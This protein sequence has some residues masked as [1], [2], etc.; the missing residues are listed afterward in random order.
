VLTAAMQEDPSNARIPYTLG[1]VQ[2]RLG[3][4]EAA[5]RALERFVQ[6]ASC[7]FPTQVNEV[8][9]RLAGMSQ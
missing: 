3:D 5:R 6:I 2:L 4:R 8:K 7:R 1:Q 9:R